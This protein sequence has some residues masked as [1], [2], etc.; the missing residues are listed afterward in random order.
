MRIRT[1]SPAMVIALIALFVATSGTAFAAVMITG[2]NVKNESLTGL[3]ILNGSLTTKEIRDG[4]LRPV[5][6]VGKKFPQGPQGPAGPQG[7]V[8]PQGPQGPQGPGGP[9]GPKGNQGAKGNQGPKSNQGPVG[10]KGAAG[11]QGLPGLSNLE[12][13]TGTSAVDSSTSKGIAAVCPAG[14]RATGGG[15]VAT[16]AIGLADNVTVVGDGPTSGNKG[17]LGYAK[18]I[19]PMPLNWQLSVY[20]VCA[21]V[22]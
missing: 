19:A 5:D 1:P 20:V 2:A 13:V 21:T 9:S 17:W 18:E 12:I 3:D 8:G 14:K 10:P 15:A 7:P 4:S 16:D 6:F 22:A 11:P